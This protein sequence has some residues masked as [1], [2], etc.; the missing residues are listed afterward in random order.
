MKAQSHAP[1]ERP[2]Q[3]PDR[4]PNT[5]RTPFLRREQQ[6]RRY[7]LAFAA[8]VFVM[9]TGIGTALAGGSS[10]TSG[11]GYHCYLFFS[12]PD[13]SFAQAM[14]NDSDPHEVHYKAEEFYTKYVD[15]E[16]G[17]LKHAIGN[18]DYCAPYAG[19]D[20]QQSERRCL[21]GQCVDGRGGRCDEDFTAD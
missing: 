18:I 12:F 20:C 21:N 13:G 8:F 7:L 19:A 3:S 2:N 15:L 16:L 9:A 4:D 10:D 1:A 17:T 14:V 11:D 6:L 5:R